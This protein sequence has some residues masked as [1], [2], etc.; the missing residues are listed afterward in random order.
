MR[1]PRWSRGG[2]RVIAP[3]SLEHGCAHAHQD[4]TSSAAVPAYPSIASGRREQDHHASGFKEVDVRF[5]LSPNTMDQ[6]NKR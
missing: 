6:T 1:R 5:S 2:A 4:F 3:P